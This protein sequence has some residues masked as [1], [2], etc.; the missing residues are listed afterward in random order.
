MKL[1]L[2]DDHAIV[3]AG[4][5]RLLAIIPGVELRE[6]ANGRD[7]LTLFRE[8][9][10]DVVLLDINLPG[11]G[12][13]EL[14]RRLV[15][16]NRDARVLVFSMH[17]E[18]IYARQC[19]QA[20]ALGYVSKGA[21]P[22]EII[23]AVR[24]VAKGNR[25]I[26]RQIAQELALRV[27]EGGPAATTTEPDLTAR[28]IELLR[29]LS[30]GRSLTEMANEIGVSYKTVANTISLMK[31]KLGVSRTADLMRIAIKTGISS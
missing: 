20:G 30:Q 5:K 29:L 16:E 23:E 8:E 17:S 15:L 22:D 6:A 4:L 11:I 18:V 25:Y 31:S 26:E 28:D 14:L 9:K 19:L 13:L 21:P 24:Q 12:G 10:P 1:L 7:A 2:V 3:R 27:V